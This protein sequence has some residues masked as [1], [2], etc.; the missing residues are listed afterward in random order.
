MAFEL[1]SFTDCWALDWHYGLG[2]KI[3]GLIIVLFESITS[4]TLSSRLL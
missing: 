4:C 2:V 1:R 3:I